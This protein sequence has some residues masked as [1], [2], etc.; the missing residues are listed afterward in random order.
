M[1]RYAR[2][3]VFSHIGSAGQGKLLKSKVA[4]IGMGALGTVAANNLCRAGVG[5]IRMADRDYV[6]LVNLQRQ[7]LFDEEDAR[8]RLPKAIAAANRLA[9]VNSEI[10]LEPVVADV[11]S[12]NIEQVIAGMDLVL[13]ATDNWEIRLLLNEAC[14]A[15]QIPW[16]YCGAIGGE[17]MTMNILPG[18]DQ[19]CLRCFVT[20]VSTAPERSCSSFGVLNMI[21]NM[22]ASAQTAE[23]LK[24]LLKSDSIRQGLLSVDLWGNHITTIKINK[25]PACPVCAHR[26]YEY[27]GKAGGSRATS[28]CGSNAL[29][30]T[31]AQPVAV[32]F[33][34]L[35]AKLAPAGQVTFNQYSL[36]FSDGTYEIMLFGDGRALIKN[37]PDENKARS[38]YTEYLGL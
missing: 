36:A 11:N 4:I 27:L 2:Q 3:M 23:A 22:M 28:I 5:Y 15:R 33:A 13:D 14:H 9:R 6:E 24:I 26:Q 19:P 18:A 16:I 17:G 34:T 12:S 25:N 38:I 1:E 30:I 21:T 35:A 20:G 10:T 32:D 7:I 29:Q 37:A 31:P 8:R